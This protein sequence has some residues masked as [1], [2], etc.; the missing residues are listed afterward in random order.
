M[1]DDKKINYSINH[2]QI[3]LIDENG[4]F[5][6]VV[7]K[8]YGIGK[9]KEAGLDLVQFSGDED[10]SPV[11]KII[12]YGKYKYHQAKKDRKN[13]HNVIVVKEVRMG[14]NISDHD[15]ATKHDLVNKFLD[16]KYKVKYVLKLN[17]CPPAHHS[18]AKAKFK[19]NINAF[20]DRADLG[21]EESGDKTVSIML[22]P[23]HK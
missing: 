21:I 2:K 3:K 17:K 9:A 22:T 23:R 4:D 10:Q 12:D 16:K 13:S 1:H 19:E 6:G 8:N 11:C 7:D 15:L 18:K 5:K 20:V 14:Y